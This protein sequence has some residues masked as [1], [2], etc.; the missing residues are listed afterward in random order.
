MT[1]KNDIR[2]I[3]RFNNFKKALL[4]L[5]KFIDKSTLNELEEQGI[6]QSFEYT[7][8]LG[9]NVIKD[10]LEYSGNSKIIAGSRDAIAEAF[11]LGIIM[12][13]EGW[14]IMFKDRNQSAH[15]YNEETA[16]AISENIFKNHFN[17]F[18]ELKEMFEKKLLEK[19]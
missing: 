18:L 5:K 3:Q 6:I 12:D 13:G 2:W 15:T 16:K 8:E 10:Y 7:Y 14:M 4:Q 9:W 19:N 11:R 1:E 17:L